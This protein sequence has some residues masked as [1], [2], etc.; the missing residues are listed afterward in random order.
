[1]VGCECKAL[2]KQAHRFASCPSCHEGP[3][4]VILWWTPLKFESR[5]AAAPLVT[6]A[7]PP[8]MALQ[9]YSSLLQSRGF[10]ESYFHQVDLNKL[11]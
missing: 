10:L 7:L 6:E 4:R 3:N 8:A 9:L 1:M 5:A 2:S 11:P